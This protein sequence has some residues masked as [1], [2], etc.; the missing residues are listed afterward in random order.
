MRVPPLFS[1]VEEKCRQSVRLAG[2]LA[3]RERAMNPAQ[4]AAS[5]LAG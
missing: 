5:K 1:Q 3:R 4:N 2:E